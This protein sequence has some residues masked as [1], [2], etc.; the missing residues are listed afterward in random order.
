MPVVVATDGALV[1][2]DHV[3][4]IPPNVH[5]TIEEGCLH[6]SRLGEG[7]LRL[8]DRF[9]VSLAD[10]LGERAACVVLSGS[11]DDGAL[12]VRA[13]KQHGGLAIAQAD[14]GE[15]GFD[16]MPHSALQT[17]LL[18]ALL[19]VEEMAAFLLNYARYVCEH[20]PGVG[21][22]PD[23]APL[24]EAFID[25]LRILL[26][27]TGHDFNGYKE[28]LLL[29]RVRRR[30][31]ILQL[32][33][34]DAYVAQLGE[35]AEECRVLLRDFLI[36][37]TK[38]FRD[39]KAFAALRRQLPALLANCDLENPFRL[40]VPACATGEEVYSL[41]ILVR[42]AMAA[43]GLNIR[44]QIF[45]SD[46]D[47]A[48][49]DVARASRYHPGSI[50]ELP[51]QT[52]QRWFVERGGMVEPLRELRDMCVFSI[53][54]VLRDP[55]FSRLHLISCRNLMIYLGQ[56]L[57]EV[58]LE[59]FHFALRPDG[60]LF[61]GVSE[62][63]GR[64][65]ALFT[66]ADKR[67][68]IFRHS[69][70]SG[71]AVSRMRPNGAAL[72]FAADR[73]VAAAR[74]DWLARGA[75]RAVSRYGPVH[76][77]VDGAHQIVRFSA[78]PVSDYLDPSPGHASLGLFNLLRGSL[79]APVRR[80]VQIATQTGRAVME[81]A[82]VLLG[83]S[84][85]RDLDVIVEPLF[86]PGGNAEGL[87]S[88]VAPFFVVA[89][90]N[91]EL[92]QRGGG[93]GPGFSDAP[94]R[95]RY[96][97]GLAQIEALNEELRLAVEEHQTMNEE[98]RSANEELEASREEMQSVIEELQT[99]NI[100]LSSK[101]DALTVVNSDF[102]NLLDSTQ[103]ATLFLDG[104]TQ[105]RNFTP[106]LAELF[107]LRP[108][109]IGRPIGEI[110][111]R[112]DYTNLQADFDSV[113]ESQQVLEREVKGL[114]AS[115]RVYVLRMRPYRQANDSVDGVV[116][117]FVD[118]TQRKHAEDHMQFLAHHDPLTKLGNWAMFH[119]VMERTVAAPHD[120]EAA[121]SL[122]YMDLDR[123]KNVNDAFG[124]RV[125][126]MLLQQVAERL[127]RCLRTGDMVFRLGGDEFAV[128]QHRIRQEGDTASLA[129]RV[130]TEVSA[131]YDLEGRTVRIGVS[132]GIAFTVPGEMDSD[133]LARAAD[134]SLYDAKARG[135]GCWQI[136]RAGMRTALQQRRRLEVDLRKAV[137]R[138]ELVLMFQPL[139]RLPDR[140]I[141]GAEALLRWRHLHLGLLSPATFIPI[142]E[143]TGLIVPIGAW[144]L[145]QACREAAKWPASV[146]LS[147]NLSAIQF[148]SR[149]L[150]ETVYG[151]LSAARLPAERLAL[152]VTE[153]V[154]LQDSIN[155]Q[156]I[157]GALG[158][159]G[160]A[161]AM[162]DFGTG[163]SSLSYLRNFKVDQIKID[164]SFIRTMETQNESGVIVKAVV[165]IG[166]GLG[167]AVCAEG[168]ETEAQLEALEG[169]G[170]KL[171]QGYWL[172]MPMEA[173]ALRVLL[174]EQG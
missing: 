83:D 18:D 138:D 30:M 107:A 45:G 44:A 31:G 102:K 65:Q 105:V 91:R 146:Q 22:Q 58:L 50:A 173:S 29:R 116:V 151:A 52:R 94:G 148:A 75:Q 8:L 98:L 153:S 174:R 62:S 23:D 129:D 110:A 85:P 159:I 59:T 48:A 87:D 38:F 12:G 86:P 6:L 132:I 156:R 127:R 140:K 137:A 66:T 163:Y 144:V 162:D 49:I 149:D 73:V 88:E 60:L 158:E 11:G 96:E 14:V 123:F 56:E 61:L 4:V 25:V 67:Y 161:I 168:V 115:A 118:I 68:R 104:K 154:L 5:V 152:E 34:P 19:P 108:M 54:N 135:G 79:Q 101:N 169:F 63:L 80:A 131:P 112:L 141:V 70:L 143:E 147:V 160:V 166:E 125:G 93:H 84:A 17:G 69:G 92:T 77:V 40:W 103:I 139:V 109:D 111:A 15:G 46:I 82:V 142:A 81:P 71:P 2:A 97:A 27:Q 126:D 133:A 130:L 170:L 134:I 122:L 157:L 47:A 51:P 43:E 164:Q 55:P 145:Q 39:R 167:I 150:L 53:Q 121:A 100:E 35:D 90:H 42:E 128:L 76:V 26:R 171:V 16:A 117:T 120:A 99:V 7:S 136:F 1:Q 89:F 33:E 36:S 155:T 37:V 57:Q 172:H 74:E 10:D 124:H 24:A 72:P 119:A 32:T 64:S 165:G 95:N 114:G 9:F 78:G 13:I 21:E 28:A 113:M 41:A 106:N 3:Y 20:P